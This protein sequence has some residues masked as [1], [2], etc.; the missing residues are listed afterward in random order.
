MLHTSSRDSDGKLS[1]CDPLREMRYNI[2]MSQKT[3]DC[4]SFD[5]KA[6]GCEHLTAI[7]IHRLKPLTPTTHPTFS[8]AVR[9][10][11]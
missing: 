1:A 7:G 11:G 8:Q 6:N 5:T 9:L 4:P 2:S 10:I 3:C